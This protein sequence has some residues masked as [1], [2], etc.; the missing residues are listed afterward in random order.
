MICLPCAGLEGAAPG[1]SGWP[2]TAYNTLSRRREEG[3]KPPMYWNPDPS[4]RLFLCFGHTSRACRAS[5]SF[6]S[7][8]SHHVELTTGLL[9]AH[10]PI[11]INDMGRVSL[12]YR[13]RCCTRY[14][15]PYAAGFNSVTWADC[16]HKPSFSQY[17]QSSWHLPSGAN[18]YSSSCGA[19][20]VL[21]RTKPPLRS[22]WAWWF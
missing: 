8:L 2:L 11:A 4:T 5:L 12:S 16:A 7:L 17:V 1:S 6:R 9:V 18:G 21:T 19:K 22:C 14:D 15:G 13:S 20:T 10:T 3:A